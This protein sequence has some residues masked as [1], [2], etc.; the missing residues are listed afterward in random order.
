MACSA[1]IELR[2]AAAALAAHPA[3]GEARAEP[4]VSLRGAA[5]ALVGP[6]GALDLTV[7]ERSGLVSCGTRPGPKHTAG[8]SLAGTPGTRCGIA[9]ETI[10]PRSHAQ[11]QREAVA[12][13]GCPPN[14]ARSLG[15]PMQG[16]Q[17]GQGPR[18]CHSTLHLLCKLQQRP[19]HLQAG[20]PQ[21]LAP[22]VRCR[23]P[24]DRCA[25]PNKCAG[26]KQCVEACGAGPSSPSQLPPP[27]PPPLLPPNRLLPAGVLPCCS[28]NKVHRRGHAV[29]TGR[30]QTI[31]WCLRQ[32]SGDERQAAQHP[33]AA[34]A[35]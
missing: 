6:P 7:C 1:R 17:A 4:F 15:S 10:D 21:V 9:V 30:P 2:S 25:G 22:K 29:A 32:H 11:R 33:Q 34:G 19:R 8:S 35:G 16:G 14:G 12:G 23:A 26:F 20:A 13:L 28:R 27:L 5:A 3:S 18:A 31:P 24:C